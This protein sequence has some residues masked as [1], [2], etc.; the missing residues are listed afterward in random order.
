MPEV[1]FEE[2]PDSVKRKFVRPVVKYAPAFLGGEEA[3]QKYIQANVK[4]PETA[5][6]MGIEG[7]VKVAFTVKQTGEVSDVRIQN[8]IGSECDIEASRVVKAMPRWEPAVYQNFKVAATASLMIAFNATTKKADYVAPSRFEQSFVVTE[9]SP[10]FVGGY[11]AMMAFIQ[12]N[13][14]WPTALLK[15]KK[16][17]LIQ[18]SFIVAKDGS[19]KE[20]K[21]VKGVH[22]QLD[23]AAINVVRAMPKWK[24]GKQNGETIDV[25]YTLPIRF[26]TAP[27]APKTK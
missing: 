13:I 6:N 18:L 20:L 15:E 4:Y 2:V 22:P 23:A 12:K 21:V 8:G 25:R 17:G 26:G 16:Q 11:S 1:E 19:I 7:T 5:L 27:H 24:P 9:S 14:K 10:E 3:L